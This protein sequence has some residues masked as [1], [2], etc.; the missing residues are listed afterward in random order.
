MGIQ[1]VG[2]TYTRKALISPTK[3]TVGKDGKHH[4]YPSRARQSKLLGIAR[5]TS[6]YKRKEGESQRNLKMMDLMDKQYNTCAAMGVRQNYLK[7]E[8]YHVGKKLVRRLM[9]LMGLRAVY[10]L[11]SLSK[12]GWI[13]Y[14]MPYLLRGLQITRRNQVWSTDISYIPMENGFM[15]LYAIIDDYSRY[16]V[17]WGLCNTLDASN[18]IEVLDKAVARYGAPEIINSD[19]GVQNTCED[20][21]R[22]CDRYGMQISMDGRARCLDNV[23]I[24][25]FW[26]TVKR[27]Y[28]YLTTVDELSRGIAKYMDYYNNRRCHQGLAHQIPRAVYAAVAA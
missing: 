19:Q 4:R 13:K 1:A 26:R 28:V 10:P 12:G 9:A 8:G 25:R 16:L 24:E 21:H 17:G 14:R 22:A 11:K 7:G 20:W 15:Y 27:E 6:Y 5:S 18:A 2:D 23:W 3:E